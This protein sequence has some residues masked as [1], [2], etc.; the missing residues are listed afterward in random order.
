MLQKKYIPIL[1]ATFIWIWPTIF[2]KYLTSYFDNYTQNFYR[3]LAAAAFLVPINLIFFRKEFV[4][5]LKNI[6]QFIFPTLSV[7]AFQLLWVQSIEMLEPTVSMLL[8]KASVL[9]VA[10]FSFLLFSD[11][12]KLLSSSKFPIG[13][14]MAII[15]VTGVIIGKA[16]AQLGVFNPG[17]LLA[18]LAA[19]CWAFYLIL[20][21]T[22][23]R[24]TDPI[25]SASII[26]S[27]AVPFFFIASLL[28]GNLNVIW[29]NSARVNTILFGS[30][31][32]CVG[33]AHAFNYKS[34]KLIGASASSNFILITP[35]FTAIAS[36]FIFGEV[37]SLIQIISGTV[38]V[39]GCIVLLHAANSNRFPLSR[40]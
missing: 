40:E 35:L 33:I 18:L 32:F 12:R 34:I 3:Y 5:A 21:K 37:L 39:S 9:F 20:I 11:E 14:I 6:R 2:V 25:V 1:I 31:I 28:F 7:V 8:N 23:V 22:I 17:I 27:L 29:E 4:K 30:G 19:V 10:L 13:S 36:Y 38:L 15:G 24:R 26:F 16:N